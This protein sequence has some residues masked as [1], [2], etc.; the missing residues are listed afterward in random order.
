[1]GCFAGIPSGLWATLLVC[2]S[3]PQW[4]GR[5]YG[6]WIAFGFGVPAIVGC[7]LLYHHLLSAAFRWFKTRNP[8]S[9]APAD[10]KPTPPVPVEQTPPSDLG[11]MRIQR[12]DVE[13]ILQVDKACIGIIEHSGGEEM[14]LYLTA[15][16]RSRETN[17]SV[18]VSTPLDDECPHPGAW[19]EVIL[20]MTPA[21]ET[22]MVALNRDLE[23]P[24]HH[25][26][27][28]EGIPRSLL[29][30]YEMSTVVRFK[31]T[32]RFE[33]SRDGLI[34][35]DCEARTAGGLG[36]DPPPIR[37]AISC[38]FACKGKVSLGDRSWF[39]AIKSLI[40]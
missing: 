7:G 2:W 17:P 12:G 15:L 34:H 3:L 40:I 22:P 1:M 26:P 21:A 4:V 25:V 38:L 9:P 16:P 20:P 23:D 32:P 37:I 30:D 28:R 5:D 14:L 13:F 11:V 33:K 8:P 39:D 10:S 36:G 31:P 18:A 35:L 29:F 27:V 19:M 6:L 24:H